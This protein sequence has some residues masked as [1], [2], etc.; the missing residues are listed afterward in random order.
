MLRGIVK[1]Q[2]VSKEHLDKAKKKVEEQ[3]LQRFL[4]ILDQTEEIASDSEEAMLFA[5]RKK[6]ITD[7]DSIAMERILGKSDLFPISYLQTGLGVSEAVCRISIRNEFGAVVGYGTGFLVSEHVIMTNNHVLDTVDAALNSIAEFNYQD[8]ENCMPCPTY[9]FRLDPKRLFITDE[10]LDY[11][12]VA[13]LDNETLDKKLAD[14]GHLQLDPTLSQ[15]MQGEYVTII[16]HPNG[17]PK[18]ITL[19]ENQ[20]KSING[21]FVHYLADTDCGSSGSPVFN[22]QWSLVALHHAG[23]PDPDGSGNWVANEGIRIISI[24]ADIKSK[25]KALDENG[26]KLIVE[27]LPNSIFDDDEEPIV[28]QE[29]GYNAMFLGEE[30]EVPLPQLSEEMLAD[31]ARLK[32]GSYLLN[33]VHFSIAIKRSRGLAYY[34]A[35]N[36]DGANF[37]KIR[38]GSTRW[39]LDP[40][41]SEEHQYG[42]GVYR[43][44][45]LDKGHLVRRIDPNWG[46]DAKKANVDTF[47]YTNSAPQHKNLNQ[48]IWLGLEDYI[49]NNAKKHNLKV[50]IFTGPVFRD[51][52]MV[53]REKYRIPAEFWKV[54][55]MV[56]EDGELSATA[57]LQTQKNML[58]NLEFAYGEYKTYQVSLATIEQITGLKFGDLKSNDPMQTVESSAFVITDA[59]SIRL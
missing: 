46:E 12:L 59:D 53:Y 55:V 44:N 22:D 54:A 11:T 50:S 38:R 9:H 31:T 39:R 42:N 15:I 8:D 24:I 28:S 45:E 41:I 43:K 52:D 33:Y 27:V 30:Y 23:V 18:T 58:T 2:Q 16:Q 3:A 57:Y 10:E 32:D 1:N 13:L 48:K 4:S 40:R 17:G 20:V 5:S 29:L 51:D 34:S 37:V 25:Y 35:V 56:K 14:F 7:Y 49:L 47:Y 26:K 21:D 6:A 36:I 19:R